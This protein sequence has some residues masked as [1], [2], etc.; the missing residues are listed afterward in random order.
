ML[1][2]LVKMGKVFWSKSD[3][4][5]CQSKIDYIVEKC[6]IFVFVNNRQTGI[7]SCRDRITNENLKHVYGRPD[8]VDD[9][10]WDIM[11]FGTN[12]KPIDKH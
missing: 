12:F 8:T 9:T 7:E 1:L 3:C 5:S 2:Y 6:L 4:V 10:F 11:T